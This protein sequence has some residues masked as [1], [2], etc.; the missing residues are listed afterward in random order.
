M[1]NVN[2]TM[3]VIDSRDIIERI[4]ELDI[5][6]S[7]ESSNEDFKSFIEEYDSLVSLQEQCSDYANN[8]EHGVT[9]IHEDY[10]EDYMDEMIQ[11]CYEL[12]KDLPFWMKI[13]YDYDALKMDYTEVDF[14]DVTYFVR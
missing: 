10:F 5:L 2:N 13:T 7:G 11:D 3:E 1:S 4:Q 9:L 8:W 6:I 14:D 12:P